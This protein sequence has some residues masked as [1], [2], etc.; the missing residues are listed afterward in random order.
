MSVA[1]NIKSMGNL[2]HTIEI[3][4]D[5]VDLLLL[6]LYEQSLFQ[7]A[8][9]QHFRRNG[10]LDTW[11]LDLRVSLSRSE[12][13][14]PISLK[15]LEALEKNDVTQILGKGYG[16]FFLVGGIVSS[17][18]GIRAGLLRESQKEY[19]F[20][21][22]IEGSLDKESPLFIIDDILSSGRTAAN[23]ADRLLKEGYKP[24]GIMTVFQYGWR[25]AIQRLSQYNFMIQSL[26]TLYK[27]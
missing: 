23:I 17:G 12:F 1:L 3:H 10:K 2:R 7:A 15:M 20:K 18:T 24:I 26:A 22:Q 19:G 25:N 11:A 27:K 5:D 6:Q 21:Q 8:E 4:V 13:L 14:Q 16:S 9:K